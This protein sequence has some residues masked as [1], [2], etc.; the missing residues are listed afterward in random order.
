VQIFD[1]VAGDSYTLDWA[2]ADRA[3]GGPAVSGV[4]IKARQTLAQ[5]DDVYT[6]AR[7]V[8]RGPLPHRIKQEPLGTEMIEGV[9]V[10][11]TRVTI[12]HTQR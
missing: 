1:P 10:A 5:A 2:K 8:V 3:S 12:T 11:G 9:L 4:W 7:P 6:P